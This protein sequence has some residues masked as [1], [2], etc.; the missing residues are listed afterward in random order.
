MELSTLLY[1]LLD[2][3]WWGYVLVT[4]VLTQ[5]TI[6]SVTLYLHRGQ[7][8]M[9]LDYHPIVSHFF[10]FWL[11]LTTGQVTKEWVAVHR[12]HHAN[13]ETEGDP[14]SPVVYGINKVLWL[15]LFL[16]RA[17]AGCAETLKKYGAGTPDDWVERNVYTSHNWIGVLIML[18]VDVLLFGVL[19]GG[20]I[21]SVQMIWIPF[22]AAGVIN[23]IGHYFGYRNFELP[24]A[25]KNI[26]P[27][28]FWI[29]GEELHNNHHAYA[30]SAKFSFRPWEFD[31]GWLYIKMLSALRL[32]KVKKTAPTLIVNAQKQSLDLSTV[33]A[34]INNRFQVM[35][36]FVTHVVKNVHRE[37]LN[38]LGSVDKMH[39]SLLK[40][41]RHLMKREASALSENARKQLRKALELSPQLEQVYAMKQRLQE[42]WTRSAGTHEHLKQALED[43]CRA[44]EAS[45]IHALKEFSAR[46][47]GYEVLPAPSAA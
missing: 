32:A 35:S 23:G 18:A 7:A 19:A 13:V 6:A 45:G 11:W 26:I 41:A 21:W 33:R 29:G 31:I 42:I 20:L 15:G 14:H 24:D 4:L 37:E 25:S 40:R 17:E 28:A 2:L 22:W 3:S 36:H 8:H 34:V 39:R 16:Y 1:G 46:L 9:A 10:R 47:R 5:I 44:A 43:W 12:K 30:S 38:K 27:W